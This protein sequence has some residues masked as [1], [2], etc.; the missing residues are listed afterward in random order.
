MAD[1]TPHAPAPHDPAETWRLFIALPLPA[2]LLGGLSDLMER[3][4]KGAAFT[5]CRPTWVSPETIHLTLAFLGPRPVADVPRL[6]ACLTRAAAGCTPLRPELKG[7]GVFPD[8][9]H[10]KVLWVGLR[11]RTHQL[12]PL[13]ARLLDEFR[14]QR[15]AYD[16]KPFKPHLTIARFK[17]LTGTSAFAKVA[18]G[19]QTFHLAARECAQ[20]V[21]F[22]S[23]LEPT[24]ARHTPLHVEPLLPGAEETAETP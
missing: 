6:A 13:R 17:T 10:P 2:E 16:D 4:R 24:G 9:Q 5:P 15:I 20:L 8:W 21:L 19:H 3:L 12:E 7:L 22:R 11:E 14:A 18:A 1:S 23:Q